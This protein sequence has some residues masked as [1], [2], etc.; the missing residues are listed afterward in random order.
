MRK[1]K[2]NA[3]IIETLH[4][5]SCQTAGIGHDLADAEHLGT[6]QRHAACHD[7]SDITGAEDDD[8]FAGHEAFYVD[9]SLGTAC[10]VDTGGTGTGDAE[11]TAGTFAASHG[12]DDRLRLQTDKSRG[13]GYEGDLAAV[14]QGEHHGIRDDLDAAFADHIDVS[15]RVFGT[16]ELLAEAVQTEARVNALIQNAARLAVA[17][18]NQNIFRCQTRIKCGCRSCQTGGTAADDN[19][20]LV[21]RYASS[22]ASRS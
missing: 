3:E 9:I 13:G 5:V 2:R 17:L 16:G 19:Q 18:Q 12:E 6:F 22:S 20:F 14:R 8:F 7:Q 21:H 11:R 10:G 1:M 4:D 15:A